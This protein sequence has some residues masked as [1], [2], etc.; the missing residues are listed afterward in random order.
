M[1]KAPRRTAT[2]RV[3]RELGLQ[4]D[5]SVVV[6]GLDSPLTPDDIVLTG[7]PGDLGVAEE[8]PVES[9]SW[10][11]WL[12]DDPGAR[13]SHPKPLRAGTDRWE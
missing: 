12:D 13:F 10:F 7:I 8:L 4:G 9:E 3:V 1:M 5:G 11:L 6:Y 2:D